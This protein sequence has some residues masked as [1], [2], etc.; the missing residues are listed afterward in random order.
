VARYT[1]L[2]HTFGTKFFNHKDQQKI[3]HETNSM[4]ANA[5]RIEN[6]EKQEIWK[7]I[8]LVDVELIS[9]TVGTVKLSK[10]TT[11]VITG[12]NPAGMIL[13]R[14]NDI[15]GYVP[16]YTLKQLVRHCLFIYDC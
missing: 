15:V 5:R 16:T 11:V 14:V 2:L 9:D 4:V 13:I 10:N 12:G 1:K 6:W 7:A 8:T 3:L